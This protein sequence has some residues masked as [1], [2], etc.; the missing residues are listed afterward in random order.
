MPL[1]VSI[2]QN[3]GI[4]CGTEQEV[5]L[6]IFYST[7][8]NSM[9]STPL[10]IFSCGRPWLSL[11]QQP[12]ICLFTISLLIWK[13]EPGFLCAIHHVWHPLYGHFFKFKLKPCMITLPMCECQMHIAACNGYL[14]VIEF[15]LSHG[16]VISC[17]DDDGWQPI[18]CAICWGQVHFSCIIVHYC[19]ICWQSF[20]PIS[21]A[22]HAVDKQESYNN[23]KNLLWT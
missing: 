2:L 5:G 6:W 3:V 9:Y 22:P 21:T 13:V 14:R 12:L 15:L 10:I 23:L 7:E 4:S 19:M 18:H 8:Q 11:Q 1:S 16:A 20:G 17:M